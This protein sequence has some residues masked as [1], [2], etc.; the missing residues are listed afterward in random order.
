MK[1]TLL[2]LMLCMVS[3]MSFGQKTF[4]SK[5]FVTETVDEFGD[6]TGNMKVGI[7]AIGYFSNSATSNSDAELIISAM[8][9]T[10]WYDFYEYCGNHSSGDSFNVTFTGTT[11]HTSVSTDYPSIPYKF[12]ELCKNNDTIYV[13]MKETGSYATT[14][15]VFK[16]FGCKNFY[17]KYIET[18]GEPELITFEKMENTL[19][20][21]GHPIL[22]SEF[23]MALPKISCVKLQSPLQYKYHIGLR[24]I[25]SNGALLQLESKN[26]TIDNTPAKVDEFGYFDFDWFLTNIHS[27]SIIRIEYAK[28][29]SIYEEFKITEEQYNALIGF[30]ND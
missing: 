18:F 16:L 27:G 28:D 5:T 19:Y 12:F 3:I 20:I 9:D 26:I 4:Y 1:K 17:K 6:K 2:A 15:A 21:Y 14:T 7:K 8:K 29:P 10:S 11:T 22:K 13:K 23:T 30:V 24:G 25:F